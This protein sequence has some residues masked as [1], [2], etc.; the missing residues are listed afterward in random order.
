MTTRTK[1]KDESK[2]KVFNFRVLIVVDKDIPGFHAYA[3]SLK[4]LQIGG[5][6]E[7][8][9][10]DNAIEAAALYLKSLLKHVDPIPIDVTKQSIEQKAA[11]SKT[12]ISAQIEEIKVNL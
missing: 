4:G 10:R 6:T 5:D 9:A 8:E 11:I 7:K 1:E 12:H 2:V 3:P